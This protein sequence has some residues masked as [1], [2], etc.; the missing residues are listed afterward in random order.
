MFCF[1]YHLVHSSSLLV[2]RVAHEGGHAYNRQWKASTRFSV[3][4][5][6]M[7]A[8][9]ISMLPRTST[10]RSSDSLCI[11]LE[12]I[13]VTHLVDPILCRYYQPRTYHNA[14]LPC[15]P[16]F[17]ALC[18]LCCGGCGDQSMQHRKPF[19]AFRDKNAICG[20]LVRLI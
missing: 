10:S 16:H 17:A 15:A 6:N 2:Y 8:A 12:F 5:T 1:L 7:R 14:E 9:T 20:F 3:S 11:E 19:L 13:K 18:P 4:V